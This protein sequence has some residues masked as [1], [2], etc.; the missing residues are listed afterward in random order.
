MGVGWF[1]ICFGRFLVSGLAKLLATWL[2]DS[3]AKAAAGQAHPGPGPGPCPMSWNVALNR[4]RADYSRT[5]ASQPWL[6]MAGFG[7]ALLGFGR[8]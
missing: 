1:L 3:L 8:F 2:A 4:T 6:A 5:L 7:R